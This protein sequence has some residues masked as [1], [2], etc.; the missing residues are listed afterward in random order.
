MVSPVF[1]N[2]DPVPLAVKLTEFPVQKVVGPDAEI[3]V[4]GKGLTVTL[5]CAESIQPFAVV[6]T[7][8]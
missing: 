7:A 2:T 3:E 4:P 6:L 1:H 8:V 5:I